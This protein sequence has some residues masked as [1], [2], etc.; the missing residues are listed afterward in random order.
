VIATA[1]YIA[2]AIPGYSNFEAVLENFMNFIGYW[3]AIYEGIALSEHFVYRRSFAGYNP[4]DYDKRDRLPPG[5][6]AVLAFFCGVV[7]MVTG[8]SQSWWVGPIARR[9]G[10]PPFGGDLGF[11][12]GFAFSAVSY[13]VFRKLE[14]NYFKR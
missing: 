13:C 7:G 2:I 3:L 9:A 5:I 1:A 8:M 12:L 10:S 4:S 14:F 6:A 11:E